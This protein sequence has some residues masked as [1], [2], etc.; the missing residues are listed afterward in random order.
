MSRIQP[1]A[2]LRNAILLDAIASG[3][4]SLLLVAGAGL[5]DGLLG[6]PVALLRE[7]GLVLIPYVA[8]VAWVATR[9]TVAI[10]AVWAIIAA[11]A[12]WA[13]ASFGLLLSGW[14][15]PTALGIAFVIAQALAVAL[16]G[17]LQYMG[18]KRQLAAPA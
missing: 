5:L 4:T 9:E 13:V 12:A 3:A 18:L 6:L 2:F 11:N 10:V 1:N 17:E 8:F 15:A 16:F 7:A 14:V